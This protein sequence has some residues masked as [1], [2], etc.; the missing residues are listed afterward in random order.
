MSPNLDRCRKHQMSVILGGVSV[1]SRTR[2]GAPGRQSEPERL[3]Q[4]PG[5]KPRH[6][7][8]S[9]AAPQSDLQPTVEG[10]LCIRSEP[11]DRL[12]RHRPRPAH[13]L[14][15][16]LRGEDNMNGTA[17]APLQKWTPFDCRSLE[18]PRGR[19]RIGSQP[20]SVALWSWIAVASAWSG[21]F[22]PNGVR[23]PA[24]RLHSLQGRA[25]TLNP[26]DSDPMLTILRR[27]A[28]ITRAID[29]Q[30]E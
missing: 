11:R 26:T 28:N 2:C 13:R 8:R 25:S 4:P 3:G 6:C 17:R 1:A 19:I 23:N 22:N 18:G 16:L 9:S 14:R 5:K 20:S 12:S 27:P 21:H 30:P 10:T 7:G 24:W 29:T 15:T